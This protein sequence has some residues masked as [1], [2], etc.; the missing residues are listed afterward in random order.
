MRL[1][2]SFGRVSLIASVLGLLFLGGIAIAHFVYA[3]PV[4]EGNTGRVLTAA[5]I[6][7]FLVYLALGFVCWT[8]IGAVIMKAARPNP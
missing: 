6:V 5:E 4:S 2:R 8:V 7:H 1:L 3:V